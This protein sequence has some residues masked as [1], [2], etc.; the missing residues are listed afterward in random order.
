MIEQRANWRARAIPR[1]RPLRP[2]TATAFAL[3]AL[4]AV[5]AL[6]LGLVPAFVASPGGI[7]ILATVATAAGLYCHRL[8]R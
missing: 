8:L 2:G 1:R 3:I 6:A 7:L 5:V 4:A